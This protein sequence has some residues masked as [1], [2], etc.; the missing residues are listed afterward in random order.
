MIMAHNGH[1]ECCFNWNVYD[2]ALI[3]NFK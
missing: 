2:I 1:A 3:V